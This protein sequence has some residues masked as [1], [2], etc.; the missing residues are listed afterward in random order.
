MGKIN[1]DRPLFSRWYRTL[2]H[3]DLSNFQA[4]YKDMMRLNVKKNLETAREQMDYFMVHR[5]F[6]AVKAE[7]INRVTSTK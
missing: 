1:I 7:S 4:Y 5:N 6:N 3:H 2:A